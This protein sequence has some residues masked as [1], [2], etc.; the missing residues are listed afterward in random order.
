MPGEVPK[1]ADSTRKEL[2]NDA[3][4]ADDLR[5]G[6]IANVFGPKFRRKSKP[7]Q[8]EKEKMMDFVFPV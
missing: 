6:N 1:Q 4:V 7:S 8:R 3:L 2:P 5:L